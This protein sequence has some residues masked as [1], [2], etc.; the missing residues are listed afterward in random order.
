MC[1]LLPTYAITVMLSMQ[2]LLVLR[3]LQLGRISIHHVIHIFSSPKLCVV[4]RFARKNA[5]QDS[6][7]PGRVVSP[8]F[9]F[10]KVRPPL[11]TWAIMSP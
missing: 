9:I 5:I 1:G 3:M 11:G 2:M 6:Y 7:L 4:A 10:K 8:K